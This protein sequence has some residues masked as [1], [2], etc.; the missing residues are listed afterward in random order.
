MPIQY[1]DAEL[2]YR[3]DL[4]YPP[5][6]T[7]RH[8]GLLDSALKLNQ[9]FTA[10]AP[11]NLITF[12]T[13]QPFQ[14]G[15]RVRVTATGTLPTPLT[16][17]ADYFIIRSTATTF[18]LATTLAAA[19]AGT[20]INLIDGGSGTL[21][22]NEQALLKSDPIAVLLSKEYAAFPGYTA[23]YPIADVGAATIVSG[24]AQKS[25]TFSITN[26]GTV[27]IL[28]GHYLLIRGGTS[29]IGNLTGGYGLETLANPMA[30]SVG[31]AKGINLLLRT[32]T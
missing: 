19:I 7:I 9:P 16:A 27:D 18:K 3:N 31:E 23:R 8:V 6:G 21:N 20:E 12:T 5:T 22:L 29:A 14:T 32:P 2:L 1:S 28:I 17:A 25:A 26:N 30:I 24:R 13:A 15:A 11:S 10:D 4:Y